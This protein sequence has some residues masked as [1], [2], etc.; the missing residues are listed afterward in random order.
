MYTELKAYPHLKRARKLE[1]A[2]RRK[3]YVRRAV[4]LMDLDYFTPEDINCIEDN[5]ITVR[6]KYLWDIDI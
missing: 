2:R 4:D 6:T 3:E 5:M 1:V